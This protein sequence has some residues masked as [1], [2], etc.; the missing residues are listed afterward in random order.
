MFKETCWFL[1][2]I[3]LGPFY[4]GKLQFHSRGEECSVEFD[5]E[6]GLSKFLLGWFHTHPHQ[7]SLSPSGEDQKTM[8]AWVRTLEKP[9]ICGIINESGEQKSY[10]FK[11]DKNKKIVYQSLKTKL[12]KTFF[13]GLKK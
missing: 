2:G 12:L 6:K 10:L 5:W 1:F 7:V 9:L 13:I 4:I 8:R 11:R 3:K